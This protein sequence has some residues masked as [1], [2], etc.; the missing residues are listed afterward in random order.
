MEQNQFIN[1]KRDRLE[2][3]FEGTNFYKEFI[4]RQPD[5]EIDRRFLNFYDEV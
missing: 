4:I 2:I 1:L 5:I 3:R